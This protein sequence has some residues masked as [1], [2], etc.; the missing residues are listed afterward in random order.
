[1]EKRLIYADAAATTRI[2]PYVLEKMMPY[3]TEQ[4]GNASSLI[5]VRPARSIDKVRLP[6]HHA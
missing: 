5:Y 2:S 1:M 3:L 4:F 6:F